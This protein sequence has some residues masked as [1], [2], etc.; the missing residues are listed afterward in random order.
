MS[1]SLVERLA[2][3]TADVTFNDLP[4]AVVVESKRLVLDSL[5]CAMA[6]VNHPKGRIGID[7]GR[8]T[9][10]DSSDATIIGTNHRTSLFGAAFANGEL[11]NALDFDAVLPPGHVVPYVLPGALAVGESRAAGGAE[12]ITA[13][14]LAHEMSNRVGKAMDYHRE[15]D[16][17]KVTL[18][19][20]LGFSSTVFGATAAIGKM[21]RDTSETVANGL[22]IAATIAP[23]NTMRSWLA[24]FP[25]TTTKYLLAGSLTQSALTAAHMAEFGHRGDLQVLDDAEF[26][27]PRFIGTRRWEPGVIT[28]GLGTEW[29]FPQEQTYK[30]YPHCRVLHGLLDILSS[31]MES[32]DLR[33]EEIDAI[34]AWGEAWVDHPIWRN[35]EIE[36]V[37]DGQFSIAHGL[38]VA[39]HRIPPGPK[40]Q[41]REVV[42]NPSVLDLMGKVRFDPHPSWIDEYQRNHA[43]RPSRIEVSARGAT[44]VAEGIFPKGSPSLDPRTMMTDEELVE[45]FRVNAEGLL[46]DVQA[47]SLAAAILDLENVPD[48][49]MM[50]RMTAPGGSF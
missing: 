41:D 49:R 1:Q 47:T 25:S 42:F 32:N 7:Y 44:Y 37:V 46:S 16:Q 48:I 43:S 28:E 33:P 18:S 23:P 20:V 2:D 12:L 30:P 4:S 26:G 21:K 9:G 19:P 35:R 22:A 45:K 13:V 15:V 39:A 27:Y 38:A 40:W 11:I 34:H 3:F 31:I 6:G 10:G 36:H 29:F 14:A 5:G 24:H 17:G 8:L 50:M